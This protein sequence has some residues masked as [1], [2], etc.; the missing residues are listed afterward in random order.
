MLNYSL[1]Y[2]VSL[3]SSFHR[4]P[5]MK[6]SLKH[7]TIF[8]RELLSWELWKCRS[9][10]RERGNCF[11][12]IC[13]ILNNIK[14]PQFCVSQK[15]LSDRLKI[16][17]RD[18]K[19]RKRE[20][21]R[22]SGISPEYREIDQIMEDY[23]ERRDE[24]EAKQGK[25]STEDRNKEDQDKVSGDEMRE[26]AMERLAQSKKRNG[27]DEPRKKLHKSNETLDYLREAAERECKITQDEQEMKKKQEEGTMATQQAL[28]TQL[29]DQQQLQM[30]QQQFVQMMLNSQQAQSQAII[31]LLRKG[32]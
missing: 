23:L 25:E 27:N 8:G 15:S 19:A 31:E 12:E 21:E 14:E 22:G 1:S 16:L 2:S 32:Q 5:K 10:S 28:L 3:L 13:K 6:W 20:A 26:R 9:G 4:M 24:E 7:D 30:Q 18:C 17:E 11:E 29:R